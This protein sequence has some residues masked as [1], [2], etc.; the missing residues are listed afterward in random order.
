MRVIFYAEP[1]DAD[2]LTPKSVP[3]EESEGAAWFTTAELEQLKLS[4]PGL[5]GTELLEWARCAPGGA[6]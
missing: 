2:E 6:G 1:E 3:D 5:R 4:V